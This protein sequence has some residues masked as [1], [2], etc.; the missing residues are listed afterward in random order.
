MAEAYPWLKAIHI[1]FVIA[2]MAGL[3]YLPRLFAYH[4]DSSGTGSDTDQLFQLM[5]RR[6]LRIIMGPAMIGTWVVGFSLLT[7]PGIV[8]WGSYWL[9]IKLAAV[10]AMTW[11]HVWLSMKRKEL[12][13]GKRRTTARHFRRM[14][15]I[16]TLL[17][18]VIVVMVVVKPF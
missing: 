3:L 2:W 15:E 17:V 14:N 7:I 4:V 5:E 11:F 13:S 16:P 9:W 18:V 6:L 8:D 1:L 12:A 10:A